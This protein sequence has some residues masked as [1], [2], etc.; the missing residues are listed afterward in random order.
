MINL[1]AKVEYLG[2]NYFGFQIQNKLHVKEITIQE[3]IEKAL[4]KLF[5]DDIRI[6]YSGRTDRGVHAKG[7]VINF[8]VNTKIAPKMIKKAIN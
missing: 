1:S 7:Q 4:K 8:K 6:V 2:T 3:T 5:K